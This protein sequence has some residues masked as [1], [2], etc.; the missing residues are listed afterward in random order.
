MNLPLPPFAFA[1]ESAAFER[2]WLEEIPRRLYEL[3]IQV[4]PERNIL[5]YQYGGSWTSTDTQGAEV[6]GEFKNL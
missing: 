2:R 4:I 5:K 1:V 3:Q 6:P